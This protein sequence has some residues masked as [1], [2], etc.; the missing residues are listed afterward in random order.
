[1][2]FAQ[3]KSTYTSI[4]YV[5][6]NYFWLYWESFHFLVPDLFPKPK[7]KSWIWIWVKYYRNITEFP[8]ICIKF[9][10]FLILNPNL[11]DLTSKRY[12]NWIKIHH[13]SQALETTWGPGT[14]CARSGTN[15]QALV[16][17]LLNFHER[18]LGC[19]KPQNNIYLRLKLF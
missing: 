10:E 19:L 1:M 3:E 12:L 4:F 14:R 13:N 9:S 7:P 16:R 17:S 8:W 15:V 5:L 6:L 2:H 18:F 11:M